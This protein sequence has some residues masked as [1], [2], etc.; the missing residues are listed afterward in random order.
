MDVMI[1]ACG[2]VVRVT[3]DHGSVKEIVYGKL[4]GEVVRCKDCKHIMKVF[5]DDI[6]E[7]VA[8]ICLRE[9]EAVEV[10]GDDFCSRAERK[11]ECMHLNG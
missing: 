7:P 6:P 8:M 2:K 1:E 11:E 3:V 4:L 5:V 10:S 9:K